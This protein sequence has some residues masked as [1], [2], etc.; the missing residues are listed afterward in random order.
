VFINSY[1]RDEILEVTK[2]DF[3]HVGQ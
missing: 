2:R 1:I 3:I